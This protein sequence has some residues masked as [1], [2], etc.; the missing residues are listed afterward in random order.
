MGSRAAELISIVLMG[1]ALVV[2]E[3]TA[4]LDISGL[5]EPI[6]FELENPDTDALRRVLYA[7]SSDVFDISGEERVVRRVGNMDVLY[8][9][10]E[11]FIYQSFDSR[12]YGGTNFR[13]FRYTSNM[14]REAE[15][16]THRTHGIY[17]IEHLLDV[18]GLV[19][20]LEIHL[21]PIDRN[22]LDLAKAYIVRFDISGGSNANLRLSD[23]R[24]IWCVE[25]LPN[26]GEELTLD[27]KASLRKIEC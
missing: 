12:F 21:N 27:S 13:G 26:A 3:G 23:A 22:P 7:F 18:D 9:P 15:V 25:Y 14:W 5:V 16:E 4:V 11:D 6:S 17:K 8:T 19:E 10:T 20:H 24:P 1:G 2:S